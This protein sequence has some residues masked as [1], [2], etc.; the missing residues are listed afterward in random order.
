MD[1]D[2]NIPRLSSNI[3]RPNVV[4]SAGRSLHDITS[5]A[6]NAAGTMMPP[7]GTISRK[8]VKSMTAM[9][10]VQNRKTLAERGGEIRK[11]NQFGH[12]ASKSLNSRPVYPLLPSSTSSSSRPASAAPRN[13]SHTLNSASNSTTSR[14][15]SSARNIARP[16][17]SFGYGRTHGAASPRPLTS[18][19]TRDDDFHDSILGKRKGMDTIS[20]ACSSHASSPF[21]SLKT[22]PTPRKGSYDNQM[23]YVSDWSSSFAAQSVSHLAARETL[24]NV[25]LTTAMQGLTLNTS[26]PTLILPHGHDDAQE[27]IRPKRSSSV[28]T[29]HGIT[30]L[31]QN[32]PTPHKKSPRK[33]PP[34]VKQYLTRDS[35]VEAWDQDAKLQNMNA[36]CDMLLS[37]FHGT[38]NQSAGLKEA[39]ELYKTRL[40]EVEEKNS[41]LSE[42]NISIRVEL[43]TTKSRLSV[44]ENDLKAVARD[45]EISM[46]NLDRQ[47]RVQLETARQ[48]AKKQ[49]ENLVAKHQDEMRELHRRCD[50]QIEDERIRRQNEL[51]QMNAQTAVEIQRTRNE[52]ENK[53]RELRSVKAE[54]DRLTSDLERERTLNKELQQNLMTN[55][56][57][58]LTLESSIRA[59][60]ARIE[61]LESGNKEQSD[62]F[63]RLDQELRDAL[64][65]TSVAHAKLRKEESL[66]RKLHNQV[67]ELKGNIRVFCRVR[68]MLDNEPDA[69]AAQIEFPDS[70]ADSKEISVLGP[71][72][73]SSLGNIT[74]KNYSYSFD[75]VFGPSSQN[76]DVF[77]EISQLVQS[78]LDGYNV[79][80]FCYGQT[81]SGKT[82][83][84][85]SDDGMI[86]R[87]VHQ[88]YDTAKSL[89]EKGWHY[90]MEGNFVEVYNENLNDLLGKADEFDKKKHEIRHDMQKCKTTITDITTV[91]LDSPARVASIL[92]RAATNRS[93]AATKANER[94]SRSHSVFILKLIGENSVTG[95]RSEGTLNL[96]DLAGSE[97]LSNS[98]ATGER[99]KETQSINRSLSCLGDVIAAL[100]QGKD[101]AHI[102]YRNSKLTYLLQFSLGGNSKTLMFVMVSP[103]HE[104]LSETLTSLKF[105]TKVHNTHIGTAK[106]QTRIIRES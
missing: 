1:G 101:G 100:G 58:T 5:T 103:R 39:I 9:E 86:P 90:A 54:V 99:L 67:Q 46:D 12:S 34:K 19:S 17:T 83:T 66:R 59:L 45:H 53:D 88:I 77:E 20:L 21:P 56:S 50:A 95:E 6:N 92:R 42:Q 65:E 96:V 33:S 22:G 8:Y 68:P 74:T 64:A 60:K 82:H 63:A 97:R 40:Q 35:S 27:T 47:H 26:P 102:P 32:I 52:S 11:P 57:N 69:D 71:E 28:K 48:E 76:T 72:E 62:A 78:A 7:P 79:C 30:P 98:K 44:V 25:S 49:L 38:T 94:S 84:M 51:S 70:E 75:H 104:H 93:V 81:G 55:S 31:S 4:S 13:T 36:M 16:Q 18:M 37:R 105:A 91:N 14:A 87:A 61:F 43:D 41:Q 85:S 73:K 3:P 106:K 15:H 24:R 89:E 29:T 80:I 23:N 2:E 10:S